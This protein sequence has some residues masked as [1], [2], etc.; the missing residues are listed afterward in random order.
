MLITIIIFIIVLGV[1]VLVHEWGHFFAAR[2]F[3]VHVEEF[4]FGFPPRLFSWRGRKKPDGTRFS[5]NLLPLG[6]FV[7]IKGETSDDAVAPDSFAHQKIW[8]RVLIL[9]AGVIMNFVLAVLIFAIVYGVGVPRPLDEPGVIG[10]GA[11]VRDQKLQVM[12]VLPKSP[13]AEAGFKAED[14]VIDVGVVVRFSVGQGV[15]AVGRKKIVENLDGE[16]FKQ[17]I[18]DHASEELSVH[19]KRDEKDLLIK[20]TPRILEGGT[21]PALGVA[22]LPSGVVSY[23]WYLLPWAGVRETGYVTWQT[24]KAFGGIIQNVAQGRPIGAEISGPVGV[25]KITGVVAR[26]GF[27]YLLQLIALLSVNLA[28]INI[29]PFP[30]L[31]GGRVLFAFIEKVRGR[32]VAAKVE[33]VVHMIGFILLL[34]LIA[35]VTYRDIAR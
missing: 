31:D 5:L 7:K 23:P 6:G 24:L 9:S 22:L 30:A 34:L 16:K 20:V 1:L 35:L 26:M 18:R 32:P 17:Y 14:T 25:A 29:L 33:K 2:R 19:V 11:R 4:G 3:G 12:E 13:A 10:A 28:I 8:K 21:A 15:T 27:I